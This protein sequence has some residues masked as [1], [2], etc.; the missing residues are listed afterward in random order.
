M[1]NRLFS[2][3]IVLTVVCTLTGCV[4]RDDVYSERLDLIIPIQSTPNVTTF[5][6]GDTLYWEANFSKEVEVR[7]HDQPISLTGFDFF[8]SFVISEI[9]SEE[10]VDFNR[11]ITIA[12]DVGDV[13]M[14][15]SDQNTYPVRFREGDDAYR[16]SFGVVLLEEGLYT[17]GLQS[18]ALPEDFNHSA[19]FSCG[20]RRRSD[21]TINFQ[22]SSTDQQVYDSLYLSSPN[23][24]IQRL[25]E[26]SR[27]RDYGGIT[28]R[29]VP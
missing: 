18:F 23:P 13:G 9:G 2:L 6:V 28:F 16:L 12:Q 5:Q 22:N 29:V 15:T 17:A 3:P 20:N 1:I 4:C 10:L 21:I 24:T 8:S 7:G 11:R 19:A 26:F 27:Y 14:I 25:A